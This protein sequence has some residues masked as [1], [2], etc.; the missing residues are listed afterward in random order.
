MS[1]AANRL[2]EQL[3]QIK[4]GL[5]MMSPDRVRAMSTH[6]TDDLIEELRGVTE[7]ALK[8]VESLKG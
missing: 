3:K 4:K 8:N 7:D 6:E 5:F 2:E 1:D